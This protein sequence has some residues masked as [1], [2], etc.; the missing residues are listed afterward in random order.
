MKDQLT[1][2]VIAQEEGMT[3][4][5]FLRLRYSS[6]PSIS[7][8]AL[9]SLVEAKCCTINGRIETFSSH[10]LKKGDRVRLDTQEVKKQ[11]SVAVLYE[12][13]DLL[14]CNKSAGLVSD[15]RSFNQKLPQYKGCLELVHRLDKET[16]GVIILAK[17]AK[18]KELMM[19]LFAKREVHKAYMAL[20]DG[21]IKGDSGRIDSNIGLKR[22]YQG[23]SVYQ[24]VEKGK[25]QVALTF[26]KCIERRGAFSVL[27]C[28][29]VTGRTHQL[30]VHLSS[31]GHPILG[32]IEYGHHFRCP[33]KCKR[34]L[35]H[36]YSISFVHPIKGAELKVIAPV[37]LDIKESLVLCHA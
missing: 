10:P 3:L 15:N 32:D 18:C 8:K 16:S 34:H 1:W 36:A 11:L 5:S 29:P 27:L 23:R 31:I 14:I 25:G 19:D 30:R 22:Q 20:V 35:L 2:V 28:E 6:K 7:V 26:W 24:V 12:D 4:L 17:N 9:K 37:P 21:L 33:L 13:E